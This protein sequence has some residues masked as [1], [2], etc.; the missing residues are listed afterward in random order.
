MFEY[1]WVWS[2]DGVGFVGK[3]IVGLWWL[4]Y[5]MTTGVRSQHVPVWYGKIRFSMV[6]YISYAPVI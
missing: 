2:D 4:A 5:E 1:G 6:L 3:G